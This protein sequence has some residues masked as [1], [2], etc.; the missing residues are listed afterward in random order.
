MELL[1]GN[2]QWV[3]VAALVIAFLQVRLLRS[4]P[5]RGARSRWLQRKAEESPHLRVLSVVFQL[6]G[7]VFACLLMRG[8]RSGYEVM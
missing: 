3:I 7:L 6:L 5:S 4:G 8:I 1:K 2:I